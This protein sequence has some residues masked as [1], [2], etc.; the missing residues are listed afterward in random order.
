MIPKLGLKYSKMS[1]DEWQAIRSLVNDRNIVI[2]NAERVL[3]T[4]LGQKRLII[5]RWKTNK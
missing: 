2:K 5:R 1:T 3:F 4:G